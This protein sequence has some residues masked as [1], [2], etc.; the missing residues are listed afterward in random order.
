[1]ALPARLRAIGSSPHRAV[2][3]AN[4]SSFGRL[5]SERPTMRRRR[6]PTGRKQQIG[7]RKHVYTICVYIYHIYMYIYIN[8]SINNKKVNSLRFAYSHQPI[9][10]RRQNVCKNMLKIIRILSKSWKSIQNQSKIHSKSMN[11]QWKRGFGS[12][13]AGGRRCGG[14]GPALQ[15]GPSRFPPWFLMI[16]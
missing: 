8:I 5:P 4:S 12:F 11:N 16:F 3:S 1:M 10:N 14:G 7:T 6:K 15:V 13:W 9:G 2:S